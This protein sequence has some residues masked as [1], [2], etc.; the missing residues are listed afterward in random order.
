MTVDDG[1]LHWQTALAEAQHTLRQTPETLALCV[2]AAHPQ[3]TMETACQ[4]V[5]SMP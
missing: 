4:P 5:T 1:S 3:T 2:S